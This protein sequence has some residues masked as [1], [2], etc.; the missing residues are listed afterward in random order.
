[1]DSALSCQEKDTTAPHR[2][3]IK[4]CTTDDRLGRVSG[5]EVDLG[6]RRWKFGKPYQAIKTIVSPTL[7]EE[8]LC[9]ERNK[10]MF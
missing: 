10:R 3:T 8:E 1:M 2:K 9:D 6:D 5:D 7:I 4:A